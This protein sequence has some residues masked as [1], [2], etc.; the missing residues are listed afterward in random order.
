M[1]KVLATL[2]ALIVALPALA[3]DGFRAVYAGQGDEPDLV[4]EVAGNGD[5][6][7]GPATG[8]SY[9]LGIGGD[10]FLVAREGRN[11]VRVFQMEEM[12]A[13]MEQVLPPQFKAFFAEAVK[14]GAPTEQPSMTRLGTRTI[15]GFDGEVWRVSLGNPPEA[16]EVVLSKDPRLRPIGE[17][18]GRFIQANMLMMAPLVGAGAGDMVK[19]ARQM[20]A[21]GTPIGGDGGFQLKSA[22]AA[23]VSA[24][25]LALPAKPMTR[26]Q[27]LKS[28]A[29]GAI[30]E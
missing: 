13:V 5:F 3:S 7:V 19:E 2:V 20:L 11:R 15:A 8:D 14:D 26:D 6:R 30:S 18:M 23:T 16:R 28:L 12:A 25:R 27:I 21:L 10:F 17:A 24:D 4:V 22:G 29:P 1:H 9:G